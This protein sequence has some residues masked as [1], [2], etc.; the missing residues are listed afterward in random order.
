MTAVTVLGAACGGGADSNPVPVMLEGD[1]YAIAET[2]VTYGD[3]Y[4]AYAAVNHTNGLS[5]FFTSEGPY[6]TCPGSNETVGH[7]FRG[8]LHEEALQPPPA[9][10]AVSGNRIDYERGPF[11]EWYVNKASGLEWGFA[12]ATRPVGRDSTPGRVV[13]SF[14]QR[15]GPA[16]D[17]YG[18][19]FKLTDGS[20]DTI[21]DYGGLYV[22]DVTGQRLPIRLTGHEEGFSILVDDAQAVY[23]ITTHPQWIQQERLEAFDAEAGDDFGLSVAL[24]RDT[25]I[26]AA[27]NDTVSAGVAGGSAYV[28]VRVGDAW[29]Q[30][31]KLEASAA[32]AGDAFGLSV[33]LWDDTAIVGAPNDITSAGVG[34]GSAYVFVRNGNTWT[35]QQ[36]LEPEDPAA[37]DLFG[38]SVAIYGDTAIIGAMRDDTE[39]GPVAGSA[40]V[41]VRN[42]NTWTQRQR[43][44][45]ADAVPGDQF[46]NAVSIHGDTAII[47]AHHDDS[48]AGSA[49]VFV[50]RGGLWTQHQRIEASDGSDNDLFGISVGIWEDTA[51][52]GAFLDD[53]S[54]G[55]QNAG[56]A[57][58]FVRNGDSWTQQHKLEASDAASL[59]QFGFS[60]AVSGDVAVVGARQDATY[61]DGAQAGSAYV[62]VRSGDTWSQQQKLEAKDGARDNLFGYSVGLS[63]DTVIVGANQVDTA[64]GANAGSAYVFDGP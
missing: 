63:E 60:V 17:G 47:G 43:L 30:Q 61:A 6:I 44:G 1:I 8:Y 4:P 36:K 33:A 10:L 14:S 42:G 7:F 58:V 34:A 22:Y 62:F 52:V 31:H 32:E 56:S 46:G 9:R 40:Y 13:L 5:I 28:F 11:S 25:A 27:P 19:S 2:P 3:V 35:Q 24:S 49:Y 37:D 21:V 38:F 41:F 26:V 51:I 23:P 64:A 50:R 12:L 48:N 55:G 57:Y 15:G 54:S 16:P 29:T 20:G 39:A 18:T 53:T 59:D 45:P